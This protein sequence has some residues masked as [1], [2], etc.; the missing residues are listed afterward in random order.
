M[1]EVCVQ[2]SVL[3]Y[4]PLEPAA[5]KFALTEFHVLLLYPDRIEVFSV[6]NKETYF[7]EYHDKVR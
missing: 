6:L 7:V 5:V 2:N 1:T 4:S 3:D